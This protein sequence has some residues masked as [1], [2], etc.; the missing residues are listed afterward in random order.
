MGTSQRSKGSY[1]ERWWC[2]FFKKKGLQAERQPLSGQLG[3]EF[4]GDIKLQT[5]FGR[6]VAESK[7]QATG[8]G[9][10]FLTKTHKEQPADIYLLKQKGKP[11]FICIE[12]D[13]PLVE[14]FIR[15]LGGE[16]SA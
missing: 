6:L 4:A 11:H 10:S 8:R 5:K 7:Y 14:K 13:N 3:G 16:E 1:H 15:W 12:A 2:E 9:F